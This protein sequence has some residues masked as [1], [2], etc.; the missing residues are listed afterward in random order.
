MLC[1]GEMAWSQAIACCSA[2][3][4]DHFLLVKSA[5]AALILKKILVLDIALHITRPGLSAHLPRI[6]YE[7]PLPFP[8]L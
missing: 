8:S 4:P 2:M 6:C 1:V 7:V 5:F 3:Q